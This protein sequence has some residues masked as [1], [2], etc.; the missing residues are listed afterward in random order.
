MEYVAVLIAAAG[1]YAFGAVWY[2]INAQKWMIAAGFSE[3]QIKDGP[4]KSATPYIISAIMIIVVTGMMRHMFGMAG[5]DTVGKGLMSG[6][7]VGLF[8]VTPWI[9]TNYAYSMRPRALSVIDGGYATIGCAI[10][11]AILGLF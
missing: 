5:I 3:E 11:G 2:M 9:V 8:I 10:I 6:L 7:G 1:A 4:S